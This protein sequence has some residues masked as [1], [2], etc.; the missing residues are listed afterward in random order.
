MNAHTIRTASAGLLLLAVGACKEATPSQP[1]PPPPPTRPALKYASIQAGLDR[2]C[3]LT[4]DGHTYCWG[5]RIPAASGDTMVTAL[6]P[7]PVAPGLTFRSLSLGD[8]HQC[9]VTAAGVMLCWGE[10]EHF[11]LGNGRNVDSLSP[12][13]VID[14]LTFTAP[15]V[16]GQYTCGLVGGLAYCWGWNVYGQLGLGLTDDFSIPWAIVGRR[17][18]VALSAGENHSCALTPDGAAYCWGLDDFGQV[19]GDSLQQ[20]CGTAACSKVPIPVKGGLAFTSISAGGSHTC[21]LTAAG[22]AYCWGRGDLGQLGDGTARTSAV[23]VAVAGGI[24]FQSVSAGMQHTCGVAVDGLAYCWGQNNFGRLG[25]GGLEAIVPQPAAVSGSLHFIA[26][27]AGALHTCALTSEGAAYCWGFGGF[28]QLGAGLPNDA[29]TPV[30]VSEPP[31][32]TAS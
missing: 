2:T 13:L 12:T 17:Q 10:N 27:S 11:Q 9:G 5:R 32:S 19:G 26:V 23:P 25:I 15:A 14:S 22:A 7:M 20:R 6:A 4:Q 24:R 21:A 1:P 30:R 31:D 29:S 28:G 18:F 3:A 16:G 8:A